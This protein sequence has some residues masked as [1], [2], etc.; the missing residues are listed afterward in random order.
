MTSQCS[1]N[2]KICQ[3][4]KS[5]DMT[6][7]HILTSISSKS[8]APRKNETVLYNIWNLFV[9][10]TPTL[11][12]M[13]TRLSTPFSSSILPIKKVIFNAIES[14]WYTLKLSRLSTPSSSSM[15]VKEGIVNAIESSWY[16]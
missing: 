2:K 6:A 8:T 11:S 14:S 9:K 4:M 7:N 16:L 13:L 5:S 15:L 12:E 3:E 10:Y 1:E